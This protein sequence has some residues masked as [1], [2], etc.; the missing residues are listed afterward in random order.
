M[1]LV[2]QPKHA[3]RGFVGFNYPLLPGEMQAHLLF[4]F[5]IDQREA[6]FLATEVIADGRG[7]LDRMLTVRLLCK[8]YA[9]AWKEQV[10]TIAY[11]L[12]MQ[13]RKVLRDLVPRPTFPQAVVAQ[14]PLLARLCDQTAEMMDNADTV[15]L[16]QYLAMAKGH[17]EAA[18]A[19]LKVV[20]QYYTSKAVPDE[21][22]DANG[23]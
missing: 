2:P 21:A 11:K 17:P 23:D 6:E 14:V 19:G 5:V 12:F 16:A 10:C 20:A 18:L 7:K 13:R 15:L 1:G 3:T 4:Q 9:D 8:Q 22:G